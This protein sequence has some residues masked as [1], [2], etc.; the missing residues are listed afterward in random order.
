MGIKKKC[1]LPYSDEKYQI[2]KHYLKSQS[3]ANK[4]ERNNS[5]SF[6][7]SMSNRNIR[8][9]LSFKISGM[10]FFDH[11]QIEIN[12]TI[13]PSF[14]AVI[15]IIIMLLSL[16]SGIDALINGSGSIWFILIGISILGLFTLMLLWQMNECKSRFE[17]NLCKRTGDG[18]KPLKKWGF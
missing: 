12:Y 11:K 9:I 6:Y 4:S 3:K 2:V 16:F 1:I 7:I 15:A 10:F 18:L 13:V 14:P 17:N 5:F 8:N